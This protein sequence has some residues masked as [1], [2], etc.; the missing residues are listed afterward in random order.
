MTA[1]PPGGWGGEQQAAPVA[2]W[3][4]PDATEADSGRTIA[5]RHLSDETVRPDVARQARAG[6]AAPARPTPGRAPGEGGRPERGRP[7]RPEGARA[8]SG[9]AAAPQEGPEL[10]S[11]AQRFGG[12]LL[13]VLLLSVVLLAAQLIT[14][15]TVPSPNTPEALPAYFRAIGIVSLTV[16]LLG[17]AYYTW[18]NAV[19][20]TLGKWLVGTRV[21]HY[22]THE[23]LRLGRG[24]VRA[25]MI[26]ALG[27]PAGLGF[28]SILGPERRGWH[29]LAANSMVVKVPPKPPRDH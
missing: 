7:D 15:F 19:G 23:P 5:R 14:G 8:A 29:D 24:L 20:Q 18:G 9:H 3:R 27:L 10:A 17:L 6:V 25:L 28:L 1:A 22:R 13:D 16:S 2:P 12:A 4:P 26:Y 21:I 11:L